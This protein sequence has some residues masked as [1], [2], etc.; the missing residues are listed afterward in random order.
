MKVTLVAALVR[1]GG[2]GGREGEPVFWD[3]ARSS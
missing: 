1:Q 2:T 3:S